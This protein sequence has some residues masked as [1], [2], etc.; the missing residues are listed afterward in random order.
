M[1]DVLQKSLI[2]FVFMAVA[3]SASSLWAIRQRENPRWLDVSVAIILLIFSA[4]ITGILQSLTNIIPDNTLKQKDIK[5][6]Y[7][8]AILIIPF[9]TANIATSLIAHALLSD[10]IYTGQIT[11]LDF[12]KKL[13]RPFLI[14]ILFPIYALPLAVLALYYF[15]IVKKYN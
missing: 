8:I 14:I 13:W 2:I 7:Q 11:F 6:Q 5:T 15:C 10:R 4:F 12:L 9:F 3:A 1:D